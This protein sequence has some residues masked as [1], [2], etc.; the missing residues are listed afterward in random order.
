MKDDEV[1]AFVKWLLRN[2]LLVNG[3]GH[4]WFKR[5]YGTLLKKWRQ[6]KKK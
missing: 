6:R 1:I 2:H 3:Y 5:R 4:K